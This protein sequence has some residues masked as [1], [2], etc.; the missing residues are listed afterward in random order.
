MEEKQVREL[1]SEI[2]ELPA[3]RG[4]YWEVTSPEVIE[5][6]MEKITDAV[7]DTDPFA[8]EKRELNKVLMGRYPFFQDLVRRSSD[9]LYTA[10]KLAITGNAIDFMVPGGT[11]NIEK[12]VQEKLDAPLSYESFS[13]FRGKLE[14]SKFVLY[15]GDN[16]GEI[17]LD[18][19]LIETIRQCCD[20]EITFVVRSLPTLNDATM[21]E[22]ADVDM[23]KVA[24]VIENGIDG[25]LPGTILNRCSDEMKALFD[26]A[27]L[28]VSKGGGNYDSLGEEK[29]Y[30][31]KIT[32]MLLSKCHPYD[33]DFGVKRFQPILS[34][35]S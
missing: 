1:T 7:G 31:N 9:P 24:G 3:L 30:L 35:P 8:L 20:R 29:D 13:T 14:A 25:P 23:E 12:T 17:V 4:R 10:V 15:I 34:V 16:S 2:M 6:V 21:R 22:A 27:D 33:R 19:L 32:F 26:R 28:I 18:K 11:A 5:Q